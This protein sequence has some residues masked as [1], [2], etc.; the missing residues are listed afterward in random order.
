MADD[1]SE[2]DKYAS[3]FILALPVFP[4]LT[5][6]FCRSRIVMRKLSDSSIDEDDMPDALKDTLTEL[7]YLPEVRSSA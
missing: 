4:Y 6:L 2:D 7:L 1:L 5:I 3:P